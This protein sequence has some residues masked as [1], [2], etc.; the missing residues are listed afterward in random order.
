MA[1]ELKTMTVGELRK[2]LSG[3]EDDVLV[4][5]EVPAGDYW[6][7][8]LLGTIRKAEHGIVKYSEYHRRYT[9][10]DAEREDKEEF[11]ETLPSVLIL[12]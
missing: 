4:G 10:L 8:T 5:F 2:L 3:V 9:I 7:S 12:S 11:P 6:R 1:N